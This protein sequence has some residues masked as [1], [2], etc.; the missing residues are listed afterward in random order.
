MSFSSV[1]AITHSNEYPN[2]YD[3]SRSS[4]NLRVPYRT[5]ISRSPEYRWWRAFPWWLLPFSCKS[6]PP[7]SCLA[8]WRG[9]RW[10]IL[11]R[12]CSLLRRCRVASHLRFSHHRVPARF[13]D[14][15]VKIVVVK[16]LRPQ[17]QPRS[18]AAPAHWR[19]HVS[20]YEASK[21]R[22]KMSIPVSS[23]ASFRTRAVRLR[24]DRETF[25]AF[26]LFSCSS[27]LV[28]SIFSKWG[29]IFPPYLKNGRCKMRVQLIRNMTFNEQEVDT[30]RTRYD[31]LNDLTLNLRKMI[32]WW[33]LNNI[34][35]W[36][37]ITHESVCFYF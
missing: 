34:S 35:E 9:A 16:T 23:R 15:H 22:R 12:K 2:I 29:H 37:M 3:I 7:P 31:N 18:S 21:R 8:F 6:S 14:C 1:Q 25:C 20:C 11:A 13:F 24:F 33:R 27:F 30:S 5:L 17:C 36:N 10:Q 19:G 28:F 4:E 26:L 32:N